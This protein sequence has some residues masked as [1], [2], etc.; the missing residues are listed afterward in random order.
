M[1]IVIFIEK[2]GLLRVNV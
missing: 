1:A 2:K